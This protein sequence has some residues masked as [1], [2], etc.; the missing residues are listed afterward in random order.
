MLKDV[1]GII[2]NESVGVF[3]GSTAE[4]ALGV[5]DTEIEGETVCEREGTTDAEGEV[6]LKLSAI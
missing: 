5:V 1:D 2:A 4:E 6:D 3:V